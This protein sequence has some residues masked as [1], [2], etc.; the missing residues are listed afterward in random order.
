MMSRT[1]GCCDDICLPCDLESSGAWLALVGGGVKACAP[2]AASPGLVSEVV[3]RLTG[4][5]LLTPL[6]SPTPPW[7]QL[8]GKGAALNLQSH[9]LAQE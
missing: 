2:Q 9:S 7:L 3:L 6:P 1:D 5:F 4:L 8:G